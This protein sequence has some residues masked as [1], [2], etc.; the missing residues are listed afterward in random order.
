MSSDFPQPAPAQPRA[1]S[2]ETAPARDWS[3]L[4]VDIP[5]FAFEPRPPAV[6]TYRPDT[7]C[8]GWST[9]QFTVRVASVR[10][11]AHRYAGKPCQDSVA[12]AAHPGTGAVV[13]AVA[14]GVSSAP[15]SHIGSRRACETAVREVCAALEHTG[16]RP[17]WRDLLDRVAGD[18]VGQLR[19]VGPPPGDPAAEIGSALVAGVIRTI[20][21]RA[22]VDLVQVGDS[23]AWVLHEGAF[24]ALLADKFSGGGAVTSTAV[25]ALPD[26]PD[27]PAI[28]QAPI[29]VG[30]ALLVGTDG[31]GDALGDGTGLVGGVFREVL[32]DAPTPLQLAHTLDFSRETF[33]DDRTLVAIWPL[34]A[35]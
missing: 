16:R 31:F 1:H 32:A 22:W 3:P 28:A 2:T 12:V 10:G 20:D 9:P 34:R 13:F 11:Y 7:V 8:D 30:A 14:D 26:V 33:D 6:G 27:E 25:M 35:G 23:S 29:P 5:T 21:G 18:M 24:T 17:D 19:R 15:H 4:V